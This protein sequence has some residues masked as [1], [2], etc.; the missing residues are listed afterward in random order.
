MPARSP[1]GGVNDTV[2]ALVLKLFAVMLA[3]CTKWEF[4]SKLTVMAEGSP[5]GAELGGAMTSAVFSDAE[6]WV[7]EGLEITGKV[8]GLVE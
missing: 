2:S 6:P 1:L 5:A 4:W 3:D 8:T 7:V